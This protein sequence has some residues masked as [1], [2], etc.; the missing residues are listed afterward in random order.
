MRPL[1]LRDF[2][3]SPEGFSVSTGVVRARSVTTRGGFRV[4]KAVPQD[5][6]ADAD[7]EYRGRWRCTLGEWSAE[8]DWGP[9]K[10]GETWTSADADPILL[11]STCAVTSETRPDQPVSSDPGQEWAGEADL[12]SSVLAQPRSAYETVT[13]TNRTRQKQPPTQPPTTPPTVPPT[14]PPTQ[15]PTTP[16]TQPPTVPPTTRP[17]TATPSESSTVTPSKPPTRKPGLPGTGV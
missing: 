2:Q 16:P 5:S 1:A 11:G 12:G 7:N 6:V 10:A 17:P 14:T 13:V 9:I 8:G 4:T 15:P 3:V